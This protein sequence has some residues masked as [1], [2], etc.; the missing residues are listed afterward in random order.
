MPDTA[1]GDASLISLLDITALLSTIWLDCEKTASDP[2]KPLLLAM[3]QSSTGI[4]DTHI[5]LLD[6]VA[7]PYSSERTYMPPAALPK[8][9]FAVSQANNFLL[10]QATVEKDEEGLLHQ[11]TI[12]PL[13]E[14][15]RTFRGALMID[16]T[17]LEREVA[18]LNSNSIRLHAAGVRCLRIHGHF[19]SP[20]NDLCQRVTS[21]L[22]GPVA[23]VARGH[24]WSISM[25]LPLETW[26]A[27]TETL[28]AYCSDMKII[29]EHGGS[30]TWPLSD[31]QISQFETFLD[32]L[33]RRLIYVKLGALH[34]RV[35]PGIP[36]SELSPAIKAMAEA[37]PKQLL[38]GSDWPHVNTGGN[39]DIETPFHQVDESAELEVI[40]RSMSEECFH[41]MLRTTP[42]FLFY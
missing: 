41:A 10:V 21:I 27:L 11:L 15:S 8:D 12:L 24:Q 4:W 18:A 31:I 29:A 20:S 5:H 39:A 37:G 42:E 23:A 16:S 7:F 36:I 32:M 25:R 6:P 19:Q 2:A 1:K 33:R 26:A 38:W 9:L 3:M 35:A 14:P 22:D 34:R 28:E 30:F 40:R 13:S 17:N